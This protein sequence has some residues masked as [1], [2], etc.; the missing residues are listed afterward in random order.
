MGM[1]ASGA[2]AFGIPV[3]AFDDEGNASPFWDKDNADW[4][5]PI[6]PDG[7]LVYYAHGYFG[8]YDEDRM[9]LGIRGV[10]CFSNYEPSDM[11]EVD[12][13]KLRVTDGEIEKANCVLAELGVEGL[14]FNDARWWLVSS[15]G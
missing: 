2:L 12:P 5:D 11:V 6:D 9:I 10:H 1:H 13:A 15:Y 7:N 14:D 8:G 3:D 4:K